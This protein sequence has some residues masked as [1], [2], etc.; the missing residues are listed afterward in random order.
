M[1]QDCQCASCVNSRAQG[2]EPLGHWVGNQ[3]TGL[4]AQQ[5][6]GIQQAAAAQL[7]QTG[8]LGQRSL[9]DGEGGVRPVFTKAAPAPTD[10]VASPAF[11]INVRLAALKVEHDKGRA[12]IESLDAQR[13]AVARGLVK[14]EGAMELLLEMGAKVDEK[15]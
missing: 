10:D 7:S 6:A 8:L 12:L 15:P 2:V 11:D 1:S 5:Q 3:W 4:A 13:A 14:V 9:G